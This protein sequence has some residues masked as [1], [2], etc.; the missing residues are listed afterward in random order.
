MLQTVYVLQIQINMKK[1]IAIVFLVVMLTL[2]SSTLSDISAQEI[3]GLLP[4]NTYEN[5]AF[6]ISGDLNGQA[7]SFIRLGVSLIF[8]LIVLYGVFVIV[9]AA[10]KIIRSEG[11]AGRY[12]EGQKMIKGVMIGIGIIFVG[13]IGL[14]VVIAFFNAGNIV[15]P[16]INAPDNVELPL[17]TE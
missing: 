6:N 14:V 5:S 3:C 4:C 8:I 10:L 7:A 13:I 2:S 15:N 16:N 12:E 1:I 17:L 11:D 9:Q